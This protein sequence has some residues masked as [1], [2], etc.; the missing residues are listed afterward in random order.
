MNSINVVLQ[1]VTEV[2]K[3]VNMTDRMWARLLASTNQPSFMDSKELQKRID[4]ETI[5]VNHMGIATT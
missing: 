5:D 2:Q 1:R 4:G 3:T